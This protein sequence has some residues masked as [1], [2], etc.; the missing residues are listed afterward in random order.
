MAAILKFCRFFKM[1]ILAYKSYINIGH[2]IGYILSFWSA[3]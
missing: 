1:Q 3:L 2:S